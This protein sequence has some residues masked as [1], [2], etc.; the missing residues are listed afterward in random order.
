M[1][2]YSL[3]FFPLKITLIANFNFNFVSWRKEKKINENFLFLLLYGVIFIIISI[4]DICVQNKDKKIN[5]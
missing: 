3:I 1:P 4:H 5:V 2:T